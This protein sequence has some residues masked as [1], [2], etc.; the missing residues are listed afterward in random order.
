MKFK[1]REVII[2]SKKYIVYE[3]IDIPKQLRGLYS[4]NDVSCI[5]ANAIGYKFLKELFLI[6]GSNKEDN[7]VYL[8]FD[9]SREVEEFHE[10]FP[11]AELHKNMVLCNY[12][13]TKMSVKALKKILEMR[14]YIKVREIELYVPAY[15]YDKIRYWS[16][17][18][19]LSVKNYSKWIML[20]S[21]YEGFCYMSREADNFTNMEDDPEEYF[22]HTHLFHLTKYEDKLDFRHYYQS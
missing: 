4:S 5:L 3:P 16:L 18:N 7:S 2:K 17:D 22:A 13:R 15:N 11:Q 21:N 14:K 9:S 6:V 19:V 12:S 20:S 1:Y 10:W 8:V